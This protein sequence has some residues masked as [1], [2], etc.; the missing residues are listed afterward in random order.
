MGRKNLREKEDEC[1][2]I[3]ARL[4]EEAVSRTDKIVKR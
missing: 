4:Y 2:G 1:N 3:R